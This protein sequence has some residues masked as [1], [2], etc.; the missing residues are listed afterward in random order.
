MSYRII[1]ELE[2]VT[3]GDVTEL[4]NDIWGQNAEDLDAA[5][6]EFKMSISKDGFPMEWEPVT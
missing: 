5:N 4:A 2:N 3:D 6:G 1:I